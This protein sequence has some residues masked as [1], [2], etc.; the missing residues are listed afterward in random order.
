M[1]VATIV[2]ARHN[3]VKIAPISC[4]LRKSFTEIIV[5]MAREFEPRNGHR[6][7]FGDGMASARVR[8]ILLSKLSCHELAAASQ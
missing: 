4:E 8:D 1:K 5:R 3:F 7:V 6:D 2:G